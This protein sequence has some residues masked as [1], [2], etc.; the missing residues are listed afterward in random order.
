MGNAGMLP[1]PR[2][3]SGAGAAWLRLGEAP[4]I[5]PQTR[6]RRGCRG[7]GKQ[8]RRGGCIKDMGGCR[9][10]IWGVQGEIG[11]GFKRWGMQRAG[12]KEWGQ[13]WGSAGKS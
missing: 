12:C 4:S 10:G 1:T 5:P 7:D 3:K 2:Q 6:S 8:G 11:E 13:M 9:G